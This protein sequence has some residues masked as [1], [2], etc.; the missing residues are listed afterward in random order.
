MKAGRWSE[1]SHSSSD[2]L[3]NQITLLCGEHARHAG[4][5]GNRVQV[6]VRSAVNDVNR[7]VSGMSDEQM[8]VTGVVGRM[9]ESAFSGVRRKVDI[10]EMFEDHIRRSLTATV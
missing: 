1:S 2:R 9:I 3:C 6:T 7:V 10:S 4:Q 8:A 5:P